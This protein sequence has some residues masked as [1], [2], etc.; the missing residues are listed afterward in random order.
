MKRSIIA[1]AIAGLVLVG[2]DQAS[3]DSAKESAASVKATATQVKEDAATTTDAVLD[4]TKK[5][6]NDSADAVKN[7]EIGRA[8]V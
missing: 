5:A 4:S 8:H 2:C 6:V 3:H 1:I 7:T